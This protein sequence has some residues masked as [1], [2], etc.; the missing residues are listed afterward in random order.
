MSLPSEQE[1]A[2]E[3]AIDDTV[4]RWFSDTQ[5]SWEICA[6]FLILTLTAVRKAVTTCLAKTQY[7]L[8]KLEVT[9]LNCICCL[10]I[11]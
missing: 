7:F 6:L 1:G 2:R 10:K 11:F 8:C 4:V 3:D 9:P 5:M